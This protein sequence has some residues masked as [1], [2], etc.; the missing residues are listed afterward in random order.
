MVTLSRQTLWGVVCNGSHCWPFGL[1]EIICMAWEDSM[2]MSVYRELREL[3]YPK[4]G[5][6]AEQRA[7]Q[8][9]AVQSR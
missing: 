2:R 4:G 6:E 8:S 5:P 3:N 1:K 7:S 9:G